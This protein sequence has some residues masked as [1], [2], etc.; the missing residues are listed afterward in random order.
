VLSYLLSHACAWHSI[1]IRLPLLA[2]TS[3][4]PDPGKLQAVTPLIQELA[5]GRGSDMLQ[6]L[7]PR[8]QEI[9]AN[10]VL[11]SLSYAEDIPA[12]STLSALFDLVQKSYET[13]E[14]ET[15]LRG[16]A[17]AMMAMVRLMNPAQRLQLGHLLVSVIKKSTPVTTIPLL[18]SV[19]DTY[20]SLRIS[21]SWRPR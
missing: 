7:D 18:G 13:E 6:R 4:I 15:A 16:A 1:D 5:S 12:S 19:T 20:N 21:N 3:T 2:S 17:T 9:Y 14:K 10:A 11:S 8:Q